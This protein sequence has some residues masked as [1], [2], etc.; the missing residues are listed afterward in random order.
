MD[1]TTAGLISDVQLSALLPDGMYEDTDLISFLNDGFFS[2]TLAFVMRHREDFYVTYEDFDPAASIDIPA[3]AIAQ[4]LKDVQVKRGDRYFSLPRLSMGEVTSNGTLHGVEGFYIQD[5]SIVFFPNAQT[6]V[7]RLVYFKR[8][9]Y[10]MDSA[11][12]ESFLITAIDT[13]INRVTVNKSIAGNVQRDL[14]LSKSY[15][16]F[17]VDVVTTINPTTGVQLYFTG[18]EIA[19]M[20]VGDYLCNT[21]YTCFPK[22][23]IEAREV[24]IQS[25][26]VKAMISMKDMDGYKLAKDAL[27]EAKA[28]IS[29]LISPRVDDEVKK[30]V[31]TSGI[32]GSTSRRGWRR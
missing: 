25:A 24:L 26:I 8:P 7:V 23:P 28:S 6:N 2:D 19:K 10:M 1:L 9:S 18:E 16:P 5:N 22:I 32:F 20:R 11:D 15:Q 27:N 3:D 13:A 14:T 30:I 21:G 31:S 4:K 12:D 17:S 29:S